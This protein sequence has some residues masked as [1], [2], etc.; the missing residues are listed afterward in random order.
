MSLSVNIC[1][2]KGGTWHETGQQDIADIDVFHELCLILET[3]RGVWRVTLYEDGVRSEE[4]RTGLT[5]YYDY[6]PS[7]ATH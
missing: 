6:Y 2:N 1:L 3:A 4:Y 7:I 5:H